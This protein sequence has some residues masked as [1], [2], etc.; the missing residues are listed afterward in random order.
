MIFEF[1]FWEL[2]TTIVFIS[3]V[4]ASMFVYWWYFVRKYIK[5]YVLKP[6]GNVYKEITMRR[7]SLKERSFK[8]AKQ[9]Y[10]LDL[11]YA[12]LD[13]RNYPKLL[14]EE[15]SPTPIEFKNVKIKG[16]SVLQ[17]F[18]ESEMFRKLFASGTEKLNVTIILGL[19]ICMVA[20]SLYAIYTISNLQTQLAELIKQGTVIGG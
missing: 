14:F 10:T 11:K 19:A 7:I 18:T 3:C 13:S 6:Y 17:S 4:T 16:G 9:Q 15:G 2:I 1:N 8:F 12:Y 5:V 20:V